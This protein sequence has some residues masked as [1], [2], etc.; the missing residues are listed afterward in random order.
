MGYYPTISAS[1]TK[2]R[3]FNKGGDFM[4]GSVHPDKNNRW[5]ISIYW[6]GK[7][8]F[9][10]HHPATGEPFFDRRSAEKQL[11]KI[12]TEIDEGI[13]NPKAWFPDS[14]MFFEAYAEEWL[15]LIDVD[16]KTLSGYKTTIRRYAIPFFERKDIRNIRYNDILAFKKFL[17]KTLSDKT[18]CN[19]IGALKTLFKHAHK[20]EDIQK[21]PPFPTLSYEPPEIVYLTM[22]QQETVFSEIPERH[23]PIFRFMQ[24]YGVRVGEAR[25]LQKDCVVNNT[26]TIR[27]A[28]GDNTLKET[29]KTGKIRQYQITPYFAEILDNM[30][31]KLGK[32]VFTREDG[33]PYTNKNLNAIWHEAC[34]KVGI[35]IKMYNGFRH[36]LGCQLLN[37]GYSISMAQKALGHKTEQMTR[38]YAEMSSAVLTDALVNRREGNVVELRKK[39]VN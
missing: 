37:M 28:F 29:T 39:A 18:V 35:E 8:Y 36:S 27:R 25:A 7:R 32:F 31:K 24:E 12:R 20:A 14:P 38:R 26:V 16:V 19:H 30:P 15:A 33:L 21:M 11:G 9:I 13:F 3:Q 4:G 1:R 5:L 17:E 23:R 10:R 2:T 6:E 22:E 34:Q